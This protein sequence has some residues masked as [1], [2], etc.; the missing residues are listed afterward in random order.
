MQLNA[1][2]SFLLSEKLKF[3]NEGK[4]VLQGDREHLYS[5]SINAMHAFIAFIFKTKQRT[6]DLDH[7][8]DRNHS[9][10]FLICF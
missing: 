2:Q 7:G 6:G 3:L 9:V 5:E 10:C 1:L 4:V 8:T